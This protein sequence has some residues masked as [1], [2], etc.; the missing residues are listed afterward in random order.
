MTNIIVY[1]WEPPPLGWMKFNV[2]GVVLEDKMG[3]RGILRD[4]K[5]VACALF[6]EWIEARGTEMAE[7]MAIKKVMD[8]YIRSSRKVHVPLI[9]ELCSFVAS[10]WLTN[11]SYRSWSLQKIFGDIDCGTNNGM[12]DALAK[13][14]ISKSSFF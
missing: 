14:G 3:C 7:I 1:Y 5:R 10:E 8:L 11:R 12:E 9:I 2:A 13:T 6:S 4:D